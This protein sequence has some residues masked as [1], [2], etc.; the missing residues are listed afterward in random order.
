MGPPF[1]S[2]K[3]KTI[4]APTAIIWKHETTQKNHE[5]QTH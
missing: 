1:N 2:K 4:A 3:M 5:N